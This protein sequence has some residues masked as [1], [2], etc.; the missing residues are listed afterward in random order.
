MFTISIPP[1][2]NLA[3][4]NKNGW[5]GV[6]KAHLAWAQNPCSTS[7]YKLCGCLLTIS[8]GIR[9]IMHGKTEI[10]S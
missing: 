6:S 7:D 3:L 1:E 8:S 9:G 5:G 2:I 4:I 10:R